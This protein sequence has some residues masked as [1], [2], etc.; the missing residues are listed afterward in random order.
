MTKLFFKNHRYYPGSA[1]ITKSESELDNKARKGQTI[2][3]CYIC[4]TYD[5]L[6]CKSGYWICPDC[7]IRE[8]IF[9]NEREE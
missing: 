1:K 9:D 6:I 8:Y 5:N 3:E 2:P 4:G 7:D